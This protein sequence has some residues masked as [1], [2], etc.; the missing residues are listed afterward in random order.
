MS[1]TYKFEELPRS[2]QNKIIANNRD[3]NIGPGF[4]SSI[5]KKYARSIEHQTGFE[6]SIGSFFGKG[7]N[8]EVQINTCSPKAINGEIKSRSNWKF[9]MGIDTDDE[10]CRQ[11]INFIESRGNMGKPV[12]TI[13]DGSSTNS[14]G[15]YVVEFSDLNKYLSKFTNFQQFIDTLNDNI[16]NWIMFL[17]EKISIEIDHLKSQLV[18]SSAIAETLERNQKDYDRFGNEIDHGYTYDQLTIEAR[19]VARQEYINS[20]HLGNYSQEVKEQID[21]TIKKLGDLGIIKAG[22]QIFKVGAKV[23]YNGVNRNKASGWLTSGGY[24]EDENTYALINGVSEAFD[25]YIKA[26]YQIETTEH[27]IE[28]YLLDSNWLFHENGKRIK[29]FTKE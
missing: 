4:G 29:L 11:I 18:R 8:I 2:I 7:N 5:T 23:I 14:D 20:W 1:Q 22:I 12:I 10:N 25:E 19:K 15:V 17:Q 24:T 13:L 28:S 6:V 26:R 21:K 9:L 27:Q 3:I 16:K